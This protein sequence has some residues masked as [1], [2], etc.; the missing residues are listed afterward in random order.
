MNF[1]FNK[2][3]NRAFDLFKKGHN[4]FI[5]GP[6]GVGKSV[7]INHIRE[8]YSDRTVFLAPTGIAAINIQGAT[9]HR[10]F[11][12]PLGV[13]G[14]HERNSVAE[15]A[16][17]VF[18][19]EAGV[20]TIV[21]DEISMCRGDLLSAIDN[22][23]RKIRKINKPFGGLQVIVVGDFYQLPPVLNKKG[24]EYEAFIKEFISEFAFDT[25]SW[26]EANFIT[27]ELDEIMRQTDAD[28]IGALNSI[29]VKDKNYATSVNF[30]NKR[31]ANNEDINEDAI[32]LCST[33]KDADT[34]NQH[35]FDE[36]EGE[37]RTYTGAKWGTFKGC[38]VPEVIELKVGAKVLICANGD[39]YVN[40][41]TG[42]VES[43]HENSIFVQLEGYGQ[44]IVVVKRHKWE[45]LDYENKGDGVKAVPI[46]GFEQFPIR[47]GWAI[48][49]HKS[50]GISLDYGIIY[51][52]RGFFCPG[53]AYVGLSRLRSLAGLG[54][55]KPLDLSDIIV[56]NRVKIFYENNRYSNL[57]NEE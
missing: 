45:E 27:V 30:L 15:K 23:L 43:M 5:S 44:E 22:Q 41:Q 46:G 16:A 52:G 39:D 31:A 13:L 10:V 8:H 34:I 51:N 24:G 50:Q 57:M 29:R 11:R 9:V 42:Y 17:A 47:L 25:D 28:F 49:V 7:L 55:I 32:F 19:K 37:I 26:K 35:N 33:N 20:K 6:G 48:T 2:G 12:F 1:K 36:L 4:L 40:G 3:Q 14:K 21:I 18:C 54:M 56:D 38:L 53:Q